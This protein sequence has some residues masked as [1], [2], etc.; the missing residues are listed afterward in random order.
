MAQKY[1]VLAL[2]NVR[3]RGLRSWLTMLG[4]FIGIAAVVSLV[5]LGGG[6]REAILGQ[7]SSMG[8][9]KLIITNAET[10]FG[11]PG[12]T[13]ISKLTDHDV[14]IINQVSGLQRV[15]PRLLRPV[16]IE[17]N[18]ATGYGYAVSMP[19][20]DKDSKF[21][22]ESFKMEAET[23]KLL[24]SGD[25]NKIVLGSDYAKQKGFDK[26]IVVGSTL[27]LQGQ[28]FE[29]IGILKPL[30]SFQMNLA[31]L[32]N[33]EDMENMLNI[34]NEYDMIVVQ[35][36]SGENLEAV[37]ENIKEKLR[38][39]RN[40]KEGNEDF[41]VQTP[42]SALNS[43]NTILTIV[44]LIVAAIAGISLLVGG[45]GIANTMYTSVLERT[46]E[47]GVMKAIGARNSDILLIFLFEAGLLGLVGGIIG[48][49]MGVALSFGVAAIANT[50][51]GSELFRVTFSLPLV[52]GA[53][54]FSFLIGIISGVF[55]A[56]QASKLNPVDALRK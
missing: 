7:F 17:F 51:M 25:K 56:L 23:G 31:I 22:Y 18:K 8:T 54:T 28:E 41:N 48:A 21:M 46:R 1:L 49:A 50:A 30:S 11:P 24:Y 2:K 10:G 5:A 52:L 15:I 13:A 37:A 55:P 32:M 35:I 19:K 34:K 12:S 45:L 4:I 26:D 47:I 3:R 44:N 9:D 42:I 43:V 33:Q 39:D 29:V 20:E 53:F 27:K 38:K 40:Q 14:D 16:S 36:A 6:L